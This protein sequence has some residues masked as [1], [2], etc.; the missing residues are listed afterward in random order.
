ML[1]KL[2]HYVAR[3]SM[4][5]IMVALIA[6]M[7]GCGGVT[8]Y[9]LTMATNPVGGGT[10][11]DLT[12]A[13]PYTAGTVVSIKAVA[14]AG[15]QFVN[16]TAP[17]GT[18]T[19]ASAAQ[20]IFTM[21]AQNVTVTA[22]FVTAYGLTMA[23]NPVGGG[24]ATDLTNAS[25]Y[26]AGTVASIKAVAAAGYQFVNW[27]A[28]AGTFGNATAA[29]TTFTMP[30][31]NITVTANFEPS[32]YGGSG[33]EGDPYQIANWHHLHNVRDYLDDHFILMNDLDST[34]AGY[35]ELAS[36]TANY[37]KGWQPIGSSDDPFTGTFDGQGY[38]ISDL[39]ISRP[40][41]GD[42]GFFGHVDREGVIE[43]VGVVNV[44][45]TGST[46]VGGL[47]GA[48][49][50]TVSNSFSTGS[51]TGNSSVGGLVGENSGT[52]SNSFS[53]GS[54]TG[55]Y[56]EYDVG[57]LVGINSGTVS[58]SCSTGS[59][60]GNGPVG[61]LV[62]ANWEG[63]VSDSFS[64]GSVTGST[65]VGGLVGTNVG[66]VSNSYSTGNVTGSIYVGGL[67][68]HKGYGTVSNSY[69]TGNVTGNECVGGLVGN[70]WDTISKCYSTGSVTGSTQ[71]GG[72][73]G[74]NYGTVSNCYATGSVTGIHWVGG[75]VG[76]NYDKSTVSN[77]YSCGN[78]TGDVKIGGLV[79]EN[80]STVSNSFWD[81]ETSG[82][83]TSDGG[84]GKNTTEMKGTATFSGVGWNIIAVANPGT[85]NSAY[86]W[87]IV[88]DETYPFLS[89][90]P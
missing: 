55:E 38:E 26:T 42:V 19:H 66:N 15:Y 43:D 63:T 82:Q 79:G 57:G 9:G 34:T 87:N 40:D 23:T 81:T 5:L 75:L 47:V 37:G 28:P 32:F 7:V 71:V 14:A 70:N 48:S 44:A 86:I 78:V 74:W 73:V 56:Y 41:E 59:V 21:P 17:A 6:G 12:N 10:A 50:G 52:V 39:S 69:S 84:T 16:W 33:T 68:G 88:D 30:A 46:Q 27:T 89:W 53:T 24:T 62:G 4:F 2:N 61:G 80:Y 25:P 76:W 45:V 72:L 54:V 31:Q 1:K 29:M 90:Q 77:S 60:T 83:A 67:V 49:N 3:L 8:R 20:T 65:Q 64:T 18:F 11:T 36:S 58:N 35:E 13:S 85:R 51:V 22:N